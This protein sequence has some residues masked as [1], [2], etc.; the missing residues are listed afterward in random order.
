[1]DMKPIGI[2]CMP[3]QT[4]FS[5]N[6]DTAGRCLELDRNDIAFAVTLEKSNRYR[7]AKLN[8]TTANLRNLRSK[9]KPAGRVP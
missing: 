4:K 9:I 6:L 3:Y 7:R 5:H 2:G 8:H 1:M